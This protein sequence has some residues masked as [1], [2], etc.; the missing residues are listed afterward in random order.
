[1]NLSGMDQS[2]DRQQGHESSP[3]PSSM[4]LS[5]LQSGRRFA[6]S[7]QNEIRTK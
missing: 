5:D 6:L 2:G 1:M 4:D 3:A 7:V